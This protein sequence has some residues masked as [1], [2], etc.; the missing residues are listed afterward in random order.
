MIGQLIQGDNGGWRNRDIYKIHLHFQP[1]TKIYSQLGHIWGHLFSMVEKEGDC[2]SGK[3]HGKKKK[4]KTTPTPN[5][6]VFI[7]GMNPSQN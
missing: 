6:C 3:E 7:N 4:K 1:S 5:C 2:F